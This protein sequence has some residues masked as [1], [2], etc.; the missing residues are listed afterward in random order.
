MIYETALIWVA[1]SCG[2]WGLFLLRRRVY[3]SSTFPL[4]MLAAAACSGL[5]LLAGQ[6]GSRALA[7]A[8][9]VGL[10]AGVCLLVVGPL[11]R[12][13][14]RR[15]NGAERWPLAR[16]LYEI[17]DVLQ[18]GTGVREERRLAAT[19]AEL[20]SGQVEQA[21]RA[22]TEV[23]DR[24]P[25]ET[26][27]AFDERIAM[28]YLTAWE[29]QR[30]VRHAEATFLRPLQAE[31]ASL[32]PGLVREV[33]APLWVELIGAYGR[34]GEVDRAAAMLEAFEV[35]VAEEPRAAPLLHR[36]RLVF[37]ALSGQLTAVRKLASAAAAGHMTKA[38]RRYWIG[39]AAGRAGDGALAEAELRHAVAGSRGR[40][41]R[42]AELALETCRGSA[43]MQLSEAAAGVAA[44]VA[45]EPVPTW[46]RAKR[47]WLTWIA[48]AVV[49]A[50]AVALA[51]TGASTDVAVLVRAGAMVRGLVADGQTWRLATAVVVH[52][53]A[54]HAIVNLIGLWVIGRLAEEIFGTLRTALLFA[55]CGVAGAAASYLAGAAGISAGASGA[56][57]GLLGAAFGELTLH[58]RHFAAALRNGMWGALLVVALATLALGT[59]VPEIDQWAHI[60][61]LGC[62]LLLGQLVSPRHRVGRVAGALAWPVIVGFVALLGWGAWSSARIDFAD[63][64]LGGPRQTV[65]FAELAVA[66]PQRWRL[67]DEELAD[68]DVFIVLAAHTLD[69]DAAAAPAAAAP[70]AAI[71]TW[72]DGE[73][74][75]ARQRDFAA[76]T[77]APRHQLPLPA[78]WQVRE[79]ELTT[80]DPLSGPQRYRAIAFARR[81]GARWIAG[82]LYA[83]Q[84]LVD[85]GAAELARI[86]ESL[87]VVPDAPPPAR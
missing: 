63:A 38:A 61:G 77:A 60:A 13:L 17:A 18:P 72:L 10:G 71:A 41:R 32:S 3:A 55:A 16:A 9:A 75:R 68:P 84:S 23:R 57:F 21:V 24:A 56:V 11:A 85:D 43:K 33:S 46:P 35:G 15:A 54:V 81:A 62:G 67:I 52:V 19:F 14:A 86:L 25:P 51:A 66:A 79:L 58:R 59:Q 50:V 26:R 44:R 80:A 74:A 8:G 27:R 1:I 83:P 69:A 2:Y 48:T 36:A 40:A 7:A 47:P 28:M 39:I 29:W 6:G 76:V 30:A 20:H 37:L 53:G 31:G 64:M 70:P 34:L 4:M 82:S 87:R 78:A 73:A 12:R 65:R 45:E 5:G 49:L 42:M 22:L